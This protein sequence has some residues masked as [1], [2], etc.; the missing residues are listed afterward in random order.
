[1]V[2][3]MATKLI[4][5]PASPSG[6]QIFFTATRDSGCVNEYLLDLDAGVILNVSISKYGVDEWIEWANDGKSVQLRYET[7]GSRFIYKL[8]IKTGKETL[9]KEETIAE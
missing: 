2:P 8:D 6:R 5:S 1:M 9:L 3:E 7:E 4:F